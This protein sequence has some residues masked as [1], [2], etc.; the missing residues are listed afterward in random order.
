MFKQPLLPLNTVLFPGMPVQLHVFEHRYKQ[1]IKDCLESEQV[2]GIVLIKEG[3][4]AFG[5]LAE[6]YD[7][8]CTARILEVQL[9][10]DD[11]LNVQVKGQDRYKILSISQEQPYLIANVE[12]YPLS[13]SDEGDLKPLCVQL[14]LLV[15]KYMHLL[16]DATEVNIDSLLFPDDPVSLAY[17]AAVILRVPPIIKQDLLTIQYTRD[18]LEELSVIYKREIPL[19]RLML[20]KGTPEEV[21]IFSIN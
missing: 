3:R 12:P 19:L 2:F 6:T 5:P 8:G 4:E 20:A 14:H 11:H 13:K 1:M 17:V 21:K 18:L 9:L 16:A 15:D 10:K 7:I